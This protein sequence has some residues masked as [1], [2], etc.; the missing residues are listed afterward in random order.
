MDNG[1]IPR[2]YA[3]ALYKFALEHEATRR[4]Y[5]EMKQ[6]IASFK[7]NPGLQKTLANPFVCRADKETLLREAAGTQAENDYLGFVKLILDNR[8]EEYAYAMAMAYRD[9]YRTANNISQVHIATAAKLPEGD[10]E[11][12]KKM[13]ADSFKSQTL[14][15]TTS[16]EPDLIGGFVIDVDDARLDASLSSELEQL[17]ITLTQS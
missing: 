2:R 5:D 17:R 6:V 3:K 13:V 11:R 9:I 12:L 4:V 10:M 16:V 15:Y 1:L 8:R 14:E 7:A